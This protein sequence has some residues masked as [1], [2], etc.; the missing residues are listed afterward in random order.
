M[1]RLAVLL[2]VLAGPA[3]AQQ[4]DC[5]A[6]NLAPPEMSY[7]AELA[8]DAAEAEMDETYRLAL[9]R[10]KTH[11]QRVAMERGSV[12]LTLEAALRDAQEAFLTYRDRACEAEAIARGGTGAPMAGVV[13]AARMTLRRTEALGVFAEVE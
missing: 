1:R 7:C 9:T 2:A 13:C 11:D 5:T 8:F 6:E 3:A 12:P 4:I 10:A